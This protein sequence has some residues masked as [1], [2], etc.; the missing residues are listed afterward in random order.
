[1]KIYREEKKVKK[2]WCLKLRE[3][4]LEVY[5]DAVDS[6]TGEGIAGLITF[7]SDG[8]IKSM[9]RSYDLL[10]GL[11]YDPSEHNNVFDEDGR[12]IIDHE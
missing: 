7:L 12:I 6:E 5:I 1:M 11:D 9:C 10:R 2:S 4:D 8:R 3:S